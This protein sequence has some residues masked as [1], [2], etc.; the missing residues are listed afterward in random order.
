MGADLRYKHTEGGGFV[1]SAPFGTHTALRFIER[2]DGIRGARIMQPDWSD[3]RA[4]GLY[5][6]FNAPHRATQR[7]PR[8]FD[9]HSA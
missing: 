2:V 8:I 9:D 6:A 7:L 4:A 3:G 5:R 1:K